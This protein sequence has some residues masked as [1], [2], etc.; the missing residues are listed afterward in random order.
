[1]LSRPMNDG[2]VPVELAERAAGLLAELRDALGDALDDGAVANELSPA[3]LAALR[4]LE[5]QGPMR[6]GELR[7]FVPGAQSTTSELVG[8]L[9]RRALVRREVDPSD[10]RATRVL[11]R[12]RATRLLDD[13]ARGNPAAVTE[14]L[15]WLV[16]ADR[17]RFVD[18]LVALR[19]LACR[20][21]AR[22]RVADPVLEAGRPDGA[23]GVV[24]R[25]H[26][27]EP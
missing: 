25:R 4:A 8:R 10:A 3:E 23:G 22:R 5:A 17:E 1:M 18:A 13:R 12:P 6:V 20:A 2:D 15:D 11:L 24:L 21:A 16:P 7:R 14:V 19:E 27:G 9:E 26:E